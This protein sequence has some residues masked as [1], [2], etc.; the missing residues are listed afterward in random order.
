MAGTYLYQRSKA[1]EILLGKFDRCVLEKRPAWLEV[2]HQT[3]RAWATLDAEVQGRK[4]LQI[5]IRVFS[6]WEFALFNWQW[7]EKAPQPN[8]TLTDSEF[9]NIHTQGI[10]FGVGFD[11]AELV[12]FLDD[13]PPA[14]S[15]KPDLNDNAVDVRPAYLLT[16]EICR[17][18]AKCSG[19]SPQRWRDTLSKKVPKG[20]ESA[21]CK[22][23][24]ELKQNGTRW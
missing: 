6:R 12:K 15:T 13:S 4:L 23:E 16:G 11:R 19:K 5:W 1:A 18:F 3:G 22:V 9:L 2:P 24:A 10:A 8:V 20:L 21:R 17:L 14:D 7:D